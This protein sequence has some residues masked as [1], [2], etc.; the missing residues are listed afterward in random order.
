MRKPKS[1]LHV[2][3][4]TGPLVALAVAIALL[5]G[6]A[7]PASAQFFNFGGF[8]GA[9]RQAP[10][11]GG[12]WFGGDFFAPFQQQPQQ[13]APRQDFSRA[14]APAK[15]DTVPERNVLVLGDAMADWLG[16]G[17]EDAYSE[18]PDMGVIRKHKTVSG[19][20]KY[21]PRGEPADWAAAAKGILATEKADAIVVMLGL[22]DRQAIREAATEKKTDKKEEKKDAR[23]KP[24]ATKPADAKPK[25]E[26][27]TDT[28]K[29]DDKPADAELSPDDATDDAPQSGAP[30]KNARSGGGL[31]EF[32]DERWV[33]LYAKKIEELIGILKSKGVPVLWVGLPAIRGQKGTADMLF[34]DA[35]YRDG[36][37]KAGITYVDIWDGFVDEAGRFLQKGPDFEGQIR[38]LRTADGVFF[39]K[40]GARKL[41]HYVERE[42]TRLLAARSGPI[43]VPIEPTTPEANVA[44]GQPAPRPLA[45]PVMPLVASSVGTDQLLGGPGSRPAAVDALAARTLVKGEALAPPAGRADDYVWPRREIG[46]EPARGDTPVA[47]TSPSGAVAAAPAQKQLLLPP[48]QQTL[49]QQQR[50]LPPPPMQIRPPQNNGP[51]LRDFFGGFGAAPRPPAPPAAAPP[52]G[53]PFAPGAPRPPGSVG[54]SAEMPPGAFMR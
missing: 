30:D 39:T 36:A 27:S 32:R 10:Q 15:R 43:A 3:T 24:D 45:G 23:G 26:G 41:A 47:A 21:Q 28:A 18:Q 31:Y 46:R 53:G 17:L 19:L 12:G 37:G 14:P 50:R 2:F 40:P 33:E 44:P 16:Y 22:H 25:P 54:R 34:L 6:I 38:Q 9:P 52:R 49:Q 29:R 48:P 11:R 5:V 1:F 7:G 13:Q 35:L 20:I 51:S 8:G 4:E 42:V